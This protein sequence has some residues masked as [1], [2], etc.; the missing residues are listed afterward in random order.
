MSDKPQPEE[1]GAATDAELEHKLRAQLRREDAPAGLTARVLARA[2][3][4]RA[5]LRRAKPPA[6]RLRRHAPAL[7][8]GAV[9]IA[10]G[11]FVTAGRVHRHRLE[12]RQAQEAR[13]HL[14]YAL[15]MTTRELSW[16]EHKVN[17]D[18]AAP[19]AAPARPAHK[20]KSAEEL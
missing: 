6:A 15:Q 14:L 8:L 13:A 10:A 16:A 20:P 17:Q 3:E 1:T 9:L 12:A 5:S 7:S 19:G 18:M 11:A 2:D 4:Q